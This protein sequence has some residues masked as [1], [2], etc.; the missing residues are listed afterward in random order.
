MSSS[1]VE[2]YYK[3]YKYILKEYGADIATIMSLFCEK[4]HLT[5]RGCFY[6]VNE[7]I[8]HYTKWS[9]NKIRRTLKEMID[10][11]L[12]YCLGH[13][14]LPKKTY[15]AVN[16]DK[17]IEVRDKQRDNKFKHTSTRISQAKL[18]EYILESVKKQNINIDDANSIWFKKIEN[19]M[20]N[21]ESLDFDTSATIQNETFPIYNN[22]ESNNNIIS[23][24]DLN[25]NL[26]KEKN[27]LKKEKENLNEAN[28]LIENKELSL[29]EK[30]KIEINNQIENEFLQFYNLYP[31]KTA[32]AQAKKAF[33]Q[34]RQG[35]HRNHK[36]IIP[37]EAIIH[38]L[39]SFIDMILK[40]NRDMKYI[41]YPATWL[42]AQDFNDFDTNIELN[43]ESPT[44]NALLEIENVII[45]ELNSVI[46]FENQP[47]KTFCDFDKVFD[48]KFLELCKERKIN[49]DKISLKNKTFYDYLK[50]KQKELNTSIENLSKSDKA[51]LFARI[52]K[53]IVNICRKYEANPFKYNGISNVSNY[54]TIYQK[55]FD[56][57]LELSFV[58]LI[59]QTIDIDNKIIE[60][61]IVKE[62]NG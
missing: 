3:S 48:E 44:E 22:K 51:N 31:R 19:E 15:Y 55:I 18:K 40:E 42:N 21:M 53:E 5:N 11:E 43:L 2:P 32:K 7:E 49:Y 14:G 10:Y 46:I 41:P 39:L 56:K 57:Y 60:Y 8:K 52:T 34:L 27:I 29:I 16:L 12:I 58:D 20:E 26:E 45:D 13:F 33:I 30:R 54:D 6:I 25:N 37:F 28:N 23:N 50:N 17:L 35:K 1:Y 62:L 59:R 61:K 38:H 47:Y 9:L 36:N 24:N 4:F